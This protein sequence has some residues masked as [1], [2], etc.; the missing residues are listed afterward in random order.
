MGMGQLTRIQPRKIPRQHRTDEKRRVL[1]PVRVRR[2]CALVP[3]EGL[4]GHRVRQ[5]GGVARVGV[6]P[7]AVV[8]FFC[9]ADL[10]R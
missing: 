3:R 10:W 7:V 9:Y 8:C 2:L 5:V 4:R 1:H 6:V